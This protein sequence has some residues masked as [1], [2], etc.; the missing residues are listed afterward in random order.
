MEEAGAGFPGVIEANAGDLTGSGVDLVVVVAIDFV[1]QDAPNFFQIGDVLQ[2]TSADNAVL[3]PAVRAFDLTFG[4]RRESIGDVHTH[5]A[6]DLAPLRIDG[7]R[8]EHMVAPNA[9]ALLDEAEDA[10]VVHIVGRASR[11]HT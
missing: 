7:I 4:L 8:L 11:V 2:S 5:Q 3:Q 9:V 10:Q 1:V 6:H